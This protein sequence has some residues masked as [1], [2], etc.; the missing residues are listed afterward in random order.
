MKNCNYKLFEEYR[1]KIDSILL[2]SDKEYDYQ[3]MLLEYWLDAEFFCNF[4]L[5]NLFPQ[6]KKYI[7]QRLNENYGRIN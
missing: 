1:H 7:K 5:A 2:H 3:M 6:L 4:E